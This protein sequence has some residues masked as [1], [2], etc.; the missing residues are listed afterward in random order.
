MSGRNCHSFLDLGR[1]E[2]SIL[3][4]DEVWKKKKKNSGSCRGVEGIENTLLHQGVEG[5]LKKISG[6]SR[7]VEDIKKISGLC[8]G[9]EGIKTL[10]STVHESAIG[11]IQVGLVREPPSVLFGW[12][13]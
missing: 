13:V 10:I 5:T 9:V 7:V 3:D 12:E 1:I 4:P 8:R 2:N 6:P 11:N